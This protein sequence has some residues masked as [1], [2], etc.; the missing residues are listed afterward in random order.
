MLIPIPQNSLKMI[1]TREIF[2]STCPYA[3]PVTLWN[4][5]YANLYSLKHF[6]RWE[7]TVETFD[8][9]LSIFILIYSSLLTPLPC[10]AK[11]DVFIHVGKFN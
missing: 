6:S 5:V 1:T 8:L 11:Q 10:G 7:L 9:Y 2:T 4:Q 3:G